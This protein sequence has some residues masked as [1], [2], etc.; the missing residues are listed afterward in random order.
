MAGQQ[1]I[2]DRW[3]HGQEHR[4]DPARRATRIRRIGWQRQGVRESRGLER[5]RRD[6][7]ENESR[8]ATLGA[9]A[10][11]IAIRARD[12]RSASSAVQRLREQ[13]DGDLRLPRGESD[14]DGADRKRRGRR[15]LRSRARSSPSRRTERDRSPSCTRTAR[16][17]FPVAAD[18]DH[19]A[20]RA[21]WSSIRAS[22]KLFTVTASFGPAPEQATPENPRQR[23]PI[24]PNSFV[25]LVFGR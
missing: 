16:A 8:H 20:A 15:S 12:R 19:G 23:P 22:H 3:S 13:D 2:R 11:R 14:R 5:D 18:G 10:V 1:C 24:L 21:R 7:H 4:H 17:S 25:V 6:R 9:C